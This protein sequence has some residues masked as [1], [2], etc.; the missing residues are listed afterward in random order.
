MP[1]GCVVCYRFP[2]FG[3]CHP[4]CGG[5]W[6]FGICKQPLT[7]I[8][9]SNQDKTHRFTKL[10]FGSAVILVCVSSLSGICR[11]LSASPQKQ[12]H[13]YKR[14]YFRC[15]WKAAEGTPAVVK[16]GFMLSYCCNKLEWREQIQ[17]SHSCSA[18]EIWGPHPF[19]W[20]KSKRPSLFV[21]QL[22]GES[23]CSVLAFSSA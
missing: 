4:C 11:H 19:H 22:R 9:K 7:H 18:L 14:P 13:M 15:P 1:A 23:V 3:V 5:L 8:F 2:A 6:C 21:W 20:L 12:C 17:T 10:D 16:D